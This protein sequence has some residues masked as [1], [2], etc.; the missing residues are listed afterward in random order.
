M[1]KRLTV[2]RNMVF[3]SPMKIPAANDASAQSNWVVRFWPWLMVMVI[4]LFVGCI[5]VRLLSTSLERDE[6]EYAYAGQLILQGIPPYELA[7]NMKLPGTYYA[8]A[9]GMAIFGQTPDGVH[10]TLLA[11]NSLT[12]IFIFLLG[13][14]LSGDIAGVAACACYAVMSASLVVLGLAAHA[15]QFVALFG[16]LGTFL[17]WNAKKADNRPGYF[18]SGLMF[19]LAFLMKQPGI[20]FG[21]FGLAFL[22]W[23]AVHDRVIK[24]RNFLFAVL[25]VLAGL[26]L[27]LSLFCVAAL[28]A[29]DFAR[30]WFWTVDYARHYAVGNTLATGLS[31][32]INRLRDQILPYGILWVL[33]VAGLAAMARAR[34]K[35]AEFLFVSALLLFSILGIVPGLTFRNHYF[36]LMLPALALVLGMGTERLSVLLRG[37]GLRWMA[38]AVLLAALAWCIFVQRWVFFQMTP[39]QVS[40]AIYPGNPVLES[41]QIAQAIHDHSK[42]D[43]LVAVVGSEPQIYFYSQR[44]SATGYI[45]TY[46]LMESQPYAGTMQKEMIDQIETNRPEF[47]VMV[48]Y[49]LSWLKSATSDLTIWKEMK[50][51]T[52]KFYEP[53]A[54]MGHQPE[55]SGASPGNSAKGAQNAPTESMILYQRKPESN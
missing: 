31:D 14:K 45:Y 15:T 33:A 29:G 41:V 19:G 47:I 25:S 50:D 12:C 10:L 16:V 3:E 43:A 28:V 37:R 7:Y 27:P 54:A 30:F 1:E 6:G 17:L 22:T 24:S 44:H 32:L 39:E 48:A 11:V 38:P 40:E 5:R 26:A 35:R 21:M 20:C 4:I 13:R 23:S 42:P 46:P 51:Y 2:P 34:E 36:V 9:L 49:K 8:Y 55:P 53:V 52:R 18:V